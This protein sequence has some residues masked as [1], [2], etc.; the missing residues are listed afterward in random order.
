MRCG[1]VGKQGCFKW[2]RRA[3]VMRTGTCADG[4]AAREALAASEARTFAAP[5]ADM[6]PACPGAEALTIVLASSPVSFSVFCAAHP[7]AQLFS[8]TRVCLREFRGRSR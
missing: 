3:V 1:K 6:N 5:P 8:L 7:C 4:K 2:E